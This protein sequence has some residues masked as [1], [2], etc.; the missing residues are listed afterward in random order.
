MV[1]YQQAGWHDLFVASAGAAAALTGL[2][3]VAVSIN[4][5]RILADRRLPIRAVE[6]LAILLGL[7]LLSVFV[8]APGQARTVLGSEVLGLGLV[9]AIV[10]VPSRFRQHRQKGEP[11]VW[12]LAPLIV[13]VSGTV[14]M[15]VAGISVVAGA[16]GGLYWLIPELILGFAGAILNAWILLV[17]IQ[18]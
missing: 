11:L 7:L 2:I 9:M 5:A 15:I 13:V 18:R 3:F 4:L 8:L 1:S 14:P 6:T 10:L 16:G 12:S 17:E